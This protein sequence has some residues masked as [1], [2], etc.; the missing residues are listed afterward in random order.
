MIGMGMAV[1]VI[2]GNRLGSDEPKIARKGTWSAFYLCTFYMAVVAVGYYLFPNIFIKPF[3][4][5]GGSADFD[6]V[7]NLT[8]NLLIFVAIYCLFDTGNIIFAAALRGAGDTRFV[9][10]TSMTMHWILLVIPTYF[11]IKYNIGL[12][13][14]WLC[15]T[16]FVLLL[17]IVFWLRFIGGK[18]ESM[19]VIERP[20]TTVPL[21]MPEVPTAESDHI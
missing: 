16:I 15:L 6:A 20:S 4:P 14:A 9:M 5:E 21:N 19:R 18:W 2:V 17:A 12:Y 1:S 11:I 3:T 7:R 13:A 8:A 10:F